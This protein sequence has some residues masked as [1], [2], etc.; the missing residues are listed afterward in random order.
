MT[1]PCSSNAPATAT[2]SSTP[3][4]T[5]P[6]SSP[7]A[8]P[9]DAETRRRGQTFYAPDGRIPLHPEVI[10]EDAGSLLAGQLCAAFVWDFELDAAAEVTSVLVRRAR[11]RSRAKLNYKGVQA[12][13]D[14]GTAAPCCS[15]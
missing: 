6:P 10:S 15:S 13:L 8:A 9:L 5:S 3:S 12:E 4:P 11:V 2:G 14:A 7:R 1:R